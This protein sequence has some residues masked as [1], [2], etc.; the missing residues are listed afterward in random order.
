MNTEGAQFD[1]PPAE[2]KSQHIVPREDSSTS[3]RGMSPVMTAAVQGSHERLQSFNAQVVAELR[4]AIQ[5]SVADIAE[6]YH[7][8]LDQ[9]RGAFEEKTADI[10]VSLSVID[11]LGFDR[12]ARLFLAEADKAGLHASDLGCE[13]EFKG[14]R[15]VITGLDHFD[16]R[17]LVRIQNLGSGENTLAVVTMVAAMLAKYRA[18][19]NENQA[20]NTP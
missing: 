5:S 19:G 6:K 20:P 7:I 10:V 3:M 1:D 2:T 16:D 8:S 14:N 15:Y 13:F 9:V 12:H 17:Y 4:A 18:R 11:R